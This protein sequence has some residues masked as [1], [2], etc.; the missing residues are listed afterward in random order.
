M[1]T[2]VIVNNL[3]ALPEVIQDSGAGFV[4]NNEDELIGA[5]EKLA[6]KPALRA[7]LGE[8]GYQA[9][10]KYWSEEAHIER[11]LNLIK[12][13]KNGRNHISVNIELNHKD[14]KSP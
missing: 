12:D 6:E 1:K 2:P 9:Y 13:I 11:Y 5:M 14:I 7:A 8:K 3:G 10:L 4:Y